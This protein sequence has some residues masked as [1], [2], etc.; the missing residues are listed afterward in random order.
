MLMGAC[1]SLPPG[2]GIQEAGQ[3]VQSRIGQAAA[4]NPE[5]PA[6]GGP[7]IA[8]INQIL[9]QPLSADSAV[10]LALLNNRGLKAALAE[11][12]VAGA[13][14]AQAGRLRNPGLSFSHLQG[15]AEMEI[16]R[17]V[18]FDLIGLLTLAKRKDI[19]QGRFEQAKLQ[20]ASAAVEL[21][22]EARK[23]YFGAVAAAQVAA[24][25]SQLQLSAQA[26]AELAER[27]GKAGNASRL[28]QARERLL[29]QEAQVHLSRARHAA[30][31]AREH[32]VRVLGLD[33]E[34]L[35][36][37]LPASLPDLPAQPKD[38]LDA[39]AQSLVL[40][41]DVQA[42]TRDVHATAAALGLTKATSFINV[43]D[44][45]YKNKSASGKPRQNGYE[46]SLELPLFD[47]GD[48]RTAKAE[49]VYMQ[50]VHRA[51]D[52][53]IRARSE[54]RE[55]FSSYRSQYEIARTYRDEIVPQ[56]KRISEEVLLRYNG[57][58]LSVFD[59][60]A[61]SREQLA[62]VNAAIDAQRDFW[63]ADTQLQ[64]AIQGGAKESMSKP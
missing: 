62:S 15:G 49:A 61:D 20:A 8:R 21:A 5:T 27:M 3:L 45:G 38:V 29:F 1:T 19:E 25:T 47:W 33:G 53:A 7:V 14:L 18:T 22:F 31:A 54:V 48:A 43:F 12:G 26:S 35:K 64:A 30:D 51:A 58:L 44:A 4:L 23:A 56:R 63:I 34:Q 10:E 41:L 32:L 37:A 6:D 39:E 60:L 55:A 46:I 2:G 16:E 42:A 11:L 17:A 28:D 40:R 36:F 13:E 59:L 57:M 52:T 9:A 24:M 50:A